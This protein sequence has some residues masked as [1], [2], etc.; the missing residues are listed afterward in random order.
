MNAV[1][2]IALFLLVS[3]SGCG[4]NQ[5][6]LHAKKI[7]EDQQRAIDFLKHNEVVIRKIGGIKDVTPHLYQM[8]HREPLPFRYI[9][10]VYGVKSTSAVVN[11]SR[12]S[13]N[14]QFTLACLGDLPPLQDDINSQFECRE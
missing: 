6:E 7:K 13:G 8:R 11:V 14:V 1:K 5:H 9:F 2:L 10:S 3:I 12:S 4:Y